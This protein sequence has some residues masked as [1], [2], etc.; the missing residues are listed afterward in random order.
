MSRSNRT[1]PGILKANTYTAGL[2]DEVRSALRAADRRVD[3]LAR[4]YGAEGFDDCE[5]VFAE[6]RHEAGNPRNWD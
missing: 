1:R 4:A 3:F 6:T 2:R 5:G